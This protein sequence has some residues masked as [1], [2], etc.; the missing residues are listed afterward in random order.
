MNLRS[1]YCG[2]NSMKIA[3]SPPPGLRRLTPCNPSMAFTLVE[4][5]VVIAIIA[6][7]AGL[8]SPALSS[9]REKAR[10]IHCLN[11]LK[12]LGLG[13]QLYARD[14]DD[15]LPPLDGDKTYDVFA[16]L[17]FPYVK[18]ASFICPT[19]N[20][21]P[22]YTKTFSTDGSDAIPINYAVNYY[23]GQWWP[24][25]NWWRY[26]FAP[27]RPEQVKNASEAAYLMDVGGTPPSDVDIYF[28]QAWADPANP[29]RILGPHSQGANVFYVDGHAA[30][31][32]K[33][34]VFAIGPY[35]SQPFWA[36]P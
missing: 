28:T 32:A 16:A 2:I 7:L 14:N 12:Q 23:F 26:G 4:L 18:K 27:R 34:A 22:G 8:L 20:K 13:A 6:M 3:P 35:V 25:D 36:Y 29:K 19:L 30:W 9:A 5:L 21:M 33:A 24:A 31:I 11:N 15:Y 10:A 17:L 1:E